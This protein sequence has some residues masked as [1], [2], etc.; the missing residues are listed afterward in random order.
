MNQYFKAINAVGSILQEYD[1][2]KNIPVFGFGAKLPYINDVSH[3][4]ALNGNIFSP[5]IHSIQGVL[6]VY[7][8]NVTKFDFSGPTNFANV[9][10]YIGEMASYYVNNGMMYKYFVLMIITDGAISDINETID[11]VIK[12]SYL[13]VSI[14]IVG[15]G[16]NEF[17]E[18][19]KLDSDTSPLYSA[20][21]NKYA[22]RD[23]VQFVPFSRFAHNPQ[24]LASQTLAEL[25]G[26]LVEYM[27]GKNIQPLKILPG[28]NPMQMESQM[29]TYY[30]ARQ[31]AFVSRIAQT[32]PMENVILS[33][34]LIA[35][36]F[37]IY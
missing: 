29:P 17:D 18:M 21:L 15:V 20:K 16:N 26:Q 1:T 36:R 3:C 6:D 12:C 23:I 27:S 24:E 30:Q 4:F 11:E 34:F 19:D 28:S 31:N 9:I 13:P 7:Q 22:M 5:E 2:D 25:P 8:K 37:R 10:G 32:A 14:I 35:F 33:T